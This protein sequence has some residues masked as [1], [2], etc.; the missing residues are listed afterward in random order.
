MEPQFSA[1]PQHATAALNQGP[2]ERRLQSPTPNV[3]NIGVNTSMP[4]YPVV[5]G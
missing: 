4:Q 3:E 2:T 5:P 1:N